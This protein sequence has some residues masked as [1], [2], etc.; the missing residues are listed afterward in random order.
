MPKNSFNVPECYENQVT[1]RQACPQITPKSG[2]YIESLPG[3]DLL[4][5]AEIAEEKTSS[6]VDLIFDKNILAIQLLETQ[7]QQRMAYWAYMLPTYPKTREFCSFS[8]TLTNAPVALERGL[9]ITQNN[10]ESPFSCV[11]IENIYVKTKTGINTNILIKDK[12]GDILNTINVDI[13]ANQLKVIIVNLCIYEDEVFVV[14]NDELIETYQSDCFNG[15]CCGELRASKFF[16][17]SGWDGQSCSRQGYGLSV[18]AGI[19]CNIS[20]LMCDVLPLIP[21][22][23]L[24]QTGIE[25]VEELLASNR[26]SIT[27]LS[28]QDW[29]EGVKESW[30]KKVDDELDILTPTFLD[31]LIRKDRHCVTCKK[32]NVK[33]SSNV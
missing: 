16:S 9:R 7:V 33:V 5:A 30:Q 26:L 27:T 24:Y 14:M 6:A 31:G 32:G 18:K 12:L 25:I 23:V 29:A 13:V 22:A 21:N 8:K 2:R 4:A 10:T 28:A 17:V 3:L 1:S 19:R 20:A 11:F 15:S